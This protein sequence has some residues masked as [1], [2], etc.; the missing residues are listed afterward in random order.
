MRSDN[1]KIRLLSAAMSIVAMVVVLC[2]CGGRETGRPVLT[3]SI[4]PQ[5]ALLE[6]IV[7]DRFEVQTLLTSGANPETFEPTMR[8]RMDV[9][10]SK[11]YFIIGGMPFETTLASTL[12][13]TVR[14]VDCAKGIALIYNTHDHGEGH[15]HIADPH[16]WSSVRNT[17]VIARNMYEAVVSI[18]AG[19]KEY[20]RSRY[21]ALV[22]RLDSIDRVWNEKLKSA[23]TRAFA[24]WHPSLS[25]FARDYGL[26]Q[27]S[28]GFENKEMPPTAMAQV[29]IEAR[30][31]GVRVLFF[32]REYDS[33]QVQSMNQMLGAR[34]VTINPLD[35]DWEGQLSAV[36]EALCR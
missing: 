33:R 30:E 24:I 17:H 7:G 6:D 18:D 14:L 12:P 23:P 1:S 11:A 13:S 32:Q 9:D 31:A 21:E 3:V 15:E 19:G 16:T 25:Y 2:G 35:Y 34:I 4:E 29:A 28:V 22:H 8:A 20:Y 27:I 5:R 36:V 26:R 10:K